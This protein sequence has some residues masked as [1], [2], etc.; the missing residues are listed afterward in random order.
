MNQPDPIF[1]AHVVKKKMKMLDHV[2]KAMALWIYTFKNGTK[3]DVIIRKTKTKRSNLQNRYYWGVVIP[4]LANYFGHDNAEDIH[5]DLK[6]KF[7]PIQSKINPEQKI[8]GS[9]TKLS[10]IE[11]FS[12]DDSYI[13]RIVRWAAMEHSVYIPPPRKI[14]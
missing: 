5:G 14:T 10:T 9:T 11:F 3:L 8:G 7:N 6:L 4:I 1:E 13:E 12:A 2:K